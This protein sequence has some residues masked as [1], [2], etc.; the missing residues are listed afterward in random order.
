MAE[1]DPLLGAGGVDLLEPAD[2]GVA[3]SSPSRARRS[4]RHRKGRARR[5]RGGRHRA[6]RGGRVAGLPG[7]PAAPR[8]LR[9]TPRR[10][11]RVAAVALAVVTMAAV[12]GAA[13][14]A[15]GV[16]GWWSDAATDT[17]PAAASDAIAPT[18][19]PQP[20]VVLVTF[21]ERDTT[22]GASQI[23]VLAHNRDTGQATAL[24]VP[25]STVAD[26]PGHGMQQLGH[27]WGY[28]D[29]A[30]LDAT[31]DNLLGVDL[32]HV[33]GVSRRGWSSL[34][35][36]SGGIEVEVS[37]R[38]EAGGPDG[39]RQ[40]RF[41]PGN[42]LLDGPRAAE[43]LTLREPGER[44]LEA[45]PRTQRVLE[46]LL[47][48]WA[49]DDDRLDAVF[50]DG[51]PMLDTP[52]APAAIRAVLAA[53]AGA[54][55]DGDL[56]VRTLPVRPMGSGVEGGY[57]L[58]DARAQRLVEN[59]LGASVPSGRG[60]A[61]RTVQILN[62]N[63]VP[64]IGQ[65]VAASVVP[66]GFTVVLTRNADRFD[67]AETRI[68]VYRDDERQLELARQL[69]DRLGVGTIVTS[70]APQSVADLTVVVGADYPPTATAAG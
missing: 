30:L 62:G 11:G 23:T 52:A 6:R 53:V 45:L 14:G 42:Q 5:R 61:G 40:T 1:R 4:D 29:G 41:D 67:H 33:V 28:G 35:T 68:L 21:D 18:G 59:R 36:R 12:T 43:L 3:A 2:E 55:A 58:D 19:D 26:I 60:E 37:E 31:L 51:A 49:A 13:V 24:F 9:T 65:E 50:G 63:G 48:Q 7:E 8:R 22:A 32:D 38:L 39:S 15:L 17:P 16:S 64:G 27:A 44:E 56:V 20:T 46:A 69:R 57:R 70:L 10:G 47:S 34:F 54:H 25:T 66:A